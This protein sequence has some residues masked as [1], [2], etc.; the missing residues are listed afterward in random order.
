VERSADPRCLSGAQKL[1]V[2]TF[3]RPPTL[4]AAANALERVWERASG[5]P[6]RHGPSVCVAPIPGR[7]RG[8]GQQRLPVLGA[9]GPLFVVNT[10][11]EDMRQPPA[12]LGV[13]LPGAE[14]QGLFGAGAPLD[15]GVLVTLRGADPSVFCTA[16]GA[17]QP[18]TDVNRTRDD[19]RW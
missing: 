6:Y 7:A 9:R 12:G 15:L 3:A 13:V 17:S 2:E 19:P 5:E 14:S 4:R 16:R 1:R 10:I 18:L 11:A 8:E